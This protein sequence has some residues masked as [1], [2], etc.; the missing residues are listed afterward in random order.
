MFGKYSLLMSLPTR[1]QAYA[2]LEP[3]RA[4]S[5]IFIV[6][7]RKAHIE[8]SGFVLG[9]L[10]A[11]RTRTA[12]LDTSCLYGV[13]VRKLAGELPKDFVQQSTLLHLSDDPGYEDSVTE[14]VAVDAPAILIDDLNAVLHLLSSQGQ[15]S[16]I[17]RLATL[18]HILSYNARLNGLLVL[19]IAYS[20]DSSGPLKRSTKRSLPNMSDLQVVTETRADEIVFQCGEIDSWPSD[21]FRAPIYFDEST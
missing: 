16:G 20:I 9:C 12:V 18:Y 10:A 3:L 5:V 21:G 13:N 2:F 8:V 4:K 15:K 1:R 19:G 11:S 7:G 6:S 14:M 17:H